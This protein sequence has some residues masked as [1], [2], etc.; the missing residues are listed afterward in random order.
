MKALNVE[1]EVV[2]DFNLMLPLFRN[3][4]LLTVLETA[5]Y[6]GVSRSMIYNLMEAGKL[7]Y[8]KIGSV[9]RIPKECCQELI[10]AHLA[11]GWQLES[12]NS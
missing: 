1:R 6:L 12:A 5:T 9:R 10:E 2:D 8:V 7:R 3:K 4:C 11:G